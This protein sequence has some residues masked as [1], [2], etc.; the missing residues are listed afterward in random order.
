MKTPIVDFV[1][2]YSRETKSRLHMPGHKGRGFL[3]AEK[4]DITEINGADSLYEA[5]GI[6]KESEQNAAKLFDTKATFYSTEGS[7]QCIKAMLYLAVS[8]KGERANLIL[9]ARNAH[10]AFLHGAALIDFE[11]KWLY[12]REFTSLCSCAITAKEL[13]E[14]LENLNVVPAAVYVTS[15]DYLGGTCDVKAL[16]DVCHKHGTL[17]IVDNAHGAYT[18]FLKPSRHP[19]DLGADM[20]CD[21]AHKTLPVLT[22]G[23]YLHISKNSDDSFAESAKNALGMFGSTSPSYLILA[24]LDYCNKYLSEG[25]EKK[26]ENCVDRLNE[27]KEHLTERGVAVKQSDPLKLTVSCCGDMRSVA[28]DLE[29]NGVYC[30]Y[31]DEEN[32]VMMFTP[33]N[34]KK[35]FKR[36]LKGL[37]NLK[38]CEKESQKATFAVPKRK[39]SV[40]QAFFSKNEMVSAD[41]AKGRICACP[42]VSCPPA[43]PVVISGEIIGEEE[44]KLFKRYGIEN[45]SVVKE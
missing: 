37:E 43:V 7:S 32:L 15:P 28:R 10:K 26:L 38:P 45:V 18:K 35:D 31:A 40:R 29:K 24:S 20:C 44:I 27:L 22:G 13:E 3:G 5:Q 25:Y 1:K 2:K 11:I 6:I 4:W 8:Q 9:A 17:L 23:A 12:P 34:S 16:A 33:E 19:I 39:L 21:S 14:Q 42:T 30:E 41:E 36:V